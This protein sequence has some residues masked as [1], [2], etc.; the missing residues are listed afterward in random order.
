MYIF[1]PSYIKP[2]HSFETCEKTFLY[3]NVVYKTILTPNFYILCQLLYG[4]INF[5]FFLTVFQVLSTLLSSPQRKREPIV[6]D[7]RYRKIWRING[8]TQHLPPP[9]FWLYRKT[10]QKARRIRR[11]RKIAAGAVR[12]LRDRATR[13]CAKELVLDSGTGQVVT[14]YFVVGK[15]FLLHLRFS[16]RPLLATGDQFLRL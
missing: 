13:R 11:L 14:K 4:Y 3:T 7:L 10:A 5:L 2:Y 12:L 9:L 8:R 1:F 15:W 16:L 6:S